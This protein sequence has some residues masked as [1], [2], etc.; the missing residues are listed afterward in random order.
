MATQTQHGQI[1][2]PTPERRR[3][4]VR[5]LQDFLNNKVSIAELKGLSRRKLFQLAE[6]GHV[7]FKYGRVAE[8]EKI[9]EALLLLD[10]RNAYFHSVMAA[11]HQKNGRIVQAIVEYSKA[12]QLNPK[13]IVSHVN[14]G[15]I[16][17]RN[18][19]FRKAAEDFRSAILMD[20]SGRNLWAN[21]AR[22][23]V[24]ALKRNIESAH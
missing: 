21:R 7:K 20:T 4:L 23:L 11:I 18:K 10:H 12:L 6:S 3:R 14:R 2:D 15:E 16:F 19:D 5:I 22:S 1:V 24:I 13:D 17:L 8:A 9:F